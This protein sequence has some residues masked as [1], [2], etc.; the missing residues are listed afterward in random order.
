MNGHTKGE[1]KVRETNLGYL[2]VTPANIPGYP[3]EET[4]IVLVTGINPN[5]QANA[6]LISAAPDMY[7][8]LKESNNVLQVLTDIIDKVDQIRAV[9]DMILQNKMVIA[10]AEASQ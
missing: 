2:I 6:Q 9:K 7:E 10:K 8:A 1:W 4:Q 3:D 5:T